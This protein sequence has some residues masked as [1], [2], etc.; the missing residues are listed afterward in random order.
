[1]ADYTVTAMLASIRRRGFIP[2]T[3]EALSDDDLIEFAN[4]E[5]YSYV[6][7]LVMSVRE[8]YFVTTKDLT[9][10][11][12]T[13]EYDIP[14]RAIG[15]KIKSVLAVDSSGSFAD[16]PRIE[17][18]RADD[19]A[20]AGGPMAYYLRGS[21]IHFV[22]APT[23]ADT[24]R[25]SY[26]AR[27]SRLVPVDEV[28]TVQSINGGRTTVTTTAT[29]PTGFSD[30]LTYDFVRA[31]PTGFESLGLDS[32][33][34]V[35]IGT[36]ITLNG[37]TVPDDIVAGDYVCLSGESPI[38]QIPVELHPLLSQRVVVRACE[39]LGQQE[40]QAAAEATAERLRQSALTMIGQRTEGAARV[41]VN[42]QA[43]GF[44]ANYRPG[45]RWR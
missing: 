43:P 25:V 26:F 12:G 1:V 17:P 30:S 22:P 21:R 33:L 27:P 13:E 36:T 15:G 44:R 23:S 10:V 32:A 41:I 3:S 14:E 4:D 6:V 31:S 42:R 20:T 40:K 29:I 35:A 8:E 9:L 2:A 5:L 7:P 24:V 19:F 28:A 34:S 16:L 38:P 37:S 18:E 45:F 11:S 39:A